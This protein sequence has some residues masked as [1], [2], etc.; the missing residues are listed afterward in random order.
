M[1]DLRAAAILMAWLALSRPAAADTFVVTSIEDEGAG[2]LRQAI[3]DA[4]AR[5]GPDTIAFSLDGPGTQTITPETPLPDISDALVIDGATQPGFAGAPLVEIDGSFAESTDTDGLRVVASDCTIR[6]LLLSRCGRAGVAVESPAAR[7]LIEKC[8][9]GTDPTGFAPM[10]CTFG[11][12]VVGASDCVVRD[13]LISG[14]AVGVAFASGASR[15][16]L[17]AC[18]IGLDA[19]GSD[20]VGTGTGVLF[21]AADSNVVAACTICGAASDAVLLQ[22]GADSNQVLDNRIGLSR[23]GDLLGNE[24]NGVTIRAGTANLVR[25]NLIEGCWGD[26]VLL[27]G[28][29]VT[30]NRIEANAILSNGYGVALTLGAAGNMVGGH[31]GADANTIAGQLGDGVAIEHVETHGNSVIGNLIAGNN[32]CGVRVA[33]SGNTIAQNRITENGLEGVL[34]AKDVWGRYPSGI[35]IR[36]NSVSDNGDM[37][38]RLEGRNDTG[39]NGR[40]PAPELILAT[41]AAGSLSVYGT[42]SA[43]P[44]TS[45]EIQFFASDEPDDSGYGE[46]AAYLGAITVVTGAGGTAAINATVSEAYA[47]QVVSA[48]ATAPTGSTSE[49]SNAVPVGDAGSTPIVTGLSPDSVLAGSFPFRLTVNGAGFMRGA[50]VLWNGAARPTS[51][52]SAERL[53]ADIPET[54]VV[55]AGTATVIVANPPPND[56]VSNPASFLINNPAPTVTSME[57]R[58]TLVGSGPTTVTLFG[59][60]FVASTVGRWN[61][62]SRPTMVLSTTKLQMT[63]AASDLL[64]SG[65]ASVTAFS[66]GPGG[67]ESG[68]LAFDILNPVPQAVSLSPSEALVGGPGLTVTVTGNGFI[69]SST[70]CWGGKARR[71]TFVSATTL[72]ATIAGSDIAKPGYGSITVVSPAPGGGTS[73]ALVFTAR[74]PVPVIKSVSPARATAGSSSMTVMLTGTGFTPVSEVRWNGVA[75]AATYVSPGDMRMVLTRADLAKPGTFGISV[76]NGA[77]GGGTSSDVPFVIGGIPQLALWTVQAVRNGDVTVSIVVRNI[78]SAPMAAGLITRAR[79]DNLDAA[80]V[81]PLP[82]SMPALQPGESAEALSCVVPAAVRGGIRLLYLNVKAGGMALTLSRTLLVPW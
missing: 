31:L 5:T 55:L 49:F 74:S 73:A 24:L 11:V 48:T 69:K 67:G 56:A 61:G 3:M 66:L 40:Q 28:S 44:N 32:A 76:V 12:L 16:R 75:H 26:G 13:C 38:I 4:N 7:V 43:A 21:D 22:N 20:L 8:R 30:S 29:G 77:P 68:S 82:I 15:N 65:S 57:P 17:E 47:G 35:T 37:G 23:Y 54:D 27:R 60:G 39:A 52:V 14:N 59:T 62:S 63:V 80:N 10:G 18:L 19:S 2:T 36:T 6:N 41:P 45:Y 50:T 25:G 78:G 9:I 33:G 46:G 71:T 34:A 64:S 53:T 51:F 42:L 72:Q 79:L 81:P 70:V 1:R 58:S